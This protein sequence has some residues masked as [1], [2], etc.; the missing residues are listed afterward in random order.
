MY[1]LTGDSVTVTEV[2]AAEDGGEATFERSVGAAETKES[3]AALYTMLSGSKFGTW[4][5]SLPFTTVGACEGVVGGEGFGLAAKVE[6]LAKADGQYKAVRG[7]VAEVA[8]P[9]VAEVGGYH[10]QTDLY[11]QLMG[12]VDACHHDTGV[13]LDCLG[14]QVARNIQQ[15][16]DDER[17]VA[18]VGADER[19]ELERYLE[20]AYVNVVNENDIDIDAIQQA[21][22]FEAVDPL[23]APDA[24]VKLVPL[25]DGASTKHLSCGK[26]TEGVHAIFSR[27]KF[28]SGN[29]NALEIDY[30]G[31]AQRSA[32]RN[33]IYPFYAPEDWSLVEIE[34]LLLLHE[35]EGLLNNTQPE[36]QWELHNRLYHE[37]IPAELLAQVLH[38]ALTS[39]EYCVNT[40]YFSRHDA[41]LLSMHY[42]SLPGRALYHRWQDVLG[43]CN[44]RTLCDLRKTLA[45]LRAAKH[46]ANLDAEE[47]PL[48]VELTQNQ[49]P[50]F[51]LEN[52]AL[53]KKSKTE[54]SDYMLN[55]V[56]PQLERVNEVFANLDE[57][58]YGNLAVREK[59]VVP[60]DG[61]IIVASGYERGFE[62][63]A[64]PAQGAATGAKAPTEK[65]SLNKVLK[66]GCFFGIVTDDG[67][68]AK[69]A[70]LKAICDAKHAEVVA[71]AG[72]DAA[73]GEEGEEG[74]AEKA[75]VTSEFS[76]I[77]TY[78]D[79]KATYGN[80]FMSFAADE[81]R[82]LV[83]METADTDYA[84]ALE[85]GAGEFEHA[86]KS[87]GAKFSYILESGQVVEVNPDGSTLVYWPLSK[88]RDAKTKIEVAGADSAHFRPGDL[89]SDAEMSRRVTSSGT[90]IRSLLSG[91]VEVYYP[92][93]TVSY[94][95]PTV[96]EL[97][98]R[99]ESE[100][101]NDW[102]KHLQIAY[103]M[104]VGSTPSEVEIS[105]GLPGHWVIVQLHGA[106][107]A[108]APAGAVQPT[109]AAGDAEAAGGEGEGG[110]GEG[111]GEAAAEKPVAA[112]EGGLYE[113]LKAEY[114]LCLVDGGN[115]AEYE[116]PPIPAA[117]QFDPH[118]H[119]SIMTTSE[120]LMV[121]VDKTHTH[122]R[123][124][125]PD[126]SVITTVMQSI[127]GST[128]ATGP[129]GQWTTMAEK[130]D[131]MPRISAKHDVLGEKGKMPASTVSIL[132]AD[133]SVA[134]LAPLKDG[135]PC[136]PFD[137]AST[138]QVIFRHSGSKS[139]LRCNGQGACDVFT[140]SDLANKGEEA[141]LKAVEKE[142]FYFSD[143]RAN[144]IKL[145]DSERNW[146]TLDG[147][148]AINFKLAVSMRDDDEKVEDP[149]CENAMQQYV[150]PDASFLP[151]P[152]GVPE[153]RL[154]VV[155]NDGEAEEVVCNYQVEEFFAQYNGNEKAV[156]TRDEPLS[157]PLVG[158]KAHTVY[159]ARMSEPTALKFQDDIV[160]PPLARGIV[161]PMSLLPPEKG[162]EFT[163]FRQFLEYPSI[164]DNRKK[165]F[166]DIREHYL[167]WEFEHSKAHMAFLKDMAEKAK[168]ERM[169]K[170][171]KGGSPKKGKKG[172][173][174]EEA[175]PPVVEP[176]EPK[177]GLFVWLLC[178]FSEGVL[179]V[180]KL[181]SHNFRQQRQR[182]NVRRTF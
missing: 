122:R 101:S 159:E 105:A 79:E 181:F 154:F 47:D 6:E 29:T 37:K 8:V 12:A 162:S 32:H 18:A 89:E 103:G 67:W 63:S 41:V 4:R 126:G 21:Q 139:V 113:L 173:Q 85:L 157:H 134:Q 87:A 110:E 16:N 106:R 24:L 147:A 129:M 71:A 138:T 130:P 72:G 112:S 83:T 15:E 22:D 48:P 1:H 94:R 104:S 5:R 75:P 70:S 96:E 26:F 150:H 136:H 151:L 69:K 170:K 174:Q 92:D 42:R 135:Q 84:S 166:H 169:K 80:F 149:A 131:V 45:A 140:K 178:S 100:A 179:C 97:N 123:V 82:V 164:T 163:S 160:M 50:N 35:F 17:A 19:I 127:N 77:V 39:N 177:G 180:C 116:L 128:L 23:G 165:D 66:D 33:R 9:T 27:L 91:R 114:G 99:A 64:F 144:T 171:K 56:L 161:N 7:R 167:K 52:E 98:G 61:S 172:K 49:I 119:E 90:L 62:D 36:R 107:T 68:D 51:T 57:R 124:I 121:I 86:C 158:C 175:P 43:M 30:L 31:N 76:D 120:K 109:P 176:E 11:N 60:N 2:P 74:A 10:G 182:R 55:T 141:L 115:T 59:C 137:V 25:I 148:Q 20:E 58:E 3:A 81:S 53:N 28:A 13:F 78:L 156:V 40:R 93:G 132:L 153:P 117:Q 88:L 118:T 168:K 152:G 146:F 46:K 102:L 44:I 143:S 95:N 111:E 65:S 54:R 108:R 125:C 155:Y 133:G 34:R 73:E 14:A 142:G 38:G 145:I